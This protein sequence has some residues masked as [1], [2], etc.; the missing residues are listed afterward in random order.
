MQKKGFNFEY[1]KCS[2]VDTTAFLQLKLIAEVQDI[3]INNLAQV[4]LC[5]DACAVLVK[6]DLNNLSINKD[7]VEFIGVRLQSTLDI[8]IKLELPHLRYSF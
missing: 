2:Q 3:H 8:E 1:K 7:F 5:P 4:E 6:I